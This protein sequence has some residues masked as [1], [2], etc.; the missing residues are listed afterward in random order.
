[1]LIRVLIQYLLEIRPKR[2]EEEQ[3]Y[4]KYVVGFEGT[5][6]VVLVNGI[7]LC[8]YECGS[9]DCE[10]DNPLTPSVSSRI[11]REKNN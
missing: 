3:E 6:G 5:K 11:I 7:L 2:W 8:M 4:I 10:G 1:M 9:R